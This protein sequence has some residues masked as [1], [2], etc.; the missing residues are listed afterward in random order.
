MFYLQRV[1]SALESALKRDRLIVAVSLG[2]IAALSWIVTARLALDMSWMA[3]G[4]SGWTAGYFTA[5]FL[6]WVVMMVAMM[7][8][9]AAPA[10][11][12]FAAGAG[13]PVTGGRRCDLCAAGLDVAN[14]P[15]GSG[16]FPDTRRGR[17]S[18]GTH[19]ARCLPQE[20]GP[21]GAGT[22]GKP[23]YP[24]GHAQAPG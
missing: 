6:M 17:R 14:D 18:G 15:A 23:G 8:P 9:S 3:L 12:L 10:I 20:R 1:A 11:L 13:H 22:Q 7:V 2:L 16:C 19:I 5:M 4:T 24:R 21:D